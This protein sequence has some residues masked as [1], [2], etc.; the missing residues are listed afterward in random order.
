MAI[1]SSVMAKANVRFFLYTLLACALF[2]PA[3]AKVPAV[4]EVICKGKTSAPC[5]LYNDISDALNKGQIQQKAI[6]AFSSRYR[7]IVGNPTTPE[8]SDAL[9]RS[10]QMLANATAVLN[11]WAAHRDKDTT[12][13]KELLKIAACK[14]TA[15]CGAEFA[16][17]VVEYSQDHHDQLTLELSKLYSKDVK[18]RKEAEA[19]LPVVKREIEGWQ[20]DLLAQAGVL[21]GR[22][23]LAGEANAVIPI[24]EQKASAHPAGNLGEFLASLIGYRQE[25]ARR[26]QTQDEHFKKGTVLNAWEVNAPPTTTKHVEV[27]EYEYMGRS[28]FGAYVLSNDGS[29]RFTGLDANGASMTRRSFK[30]NGVVESWITYVESPGAAAQV[31]RYKNGRIVFDSKPEDAATPTPA[32]KVGVLFFRDGT[33]DKLI[34]EKINEKTYAINLGGSVQELH[35]SDGNGLLGF[36]V[37]LRE[38]AAKISVEQRRSCG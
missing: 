36:N 19:P 18:P 6:V 17:H 27:A 33:A 1:Q 21:R 30:T 25:L 34:G 11:Q 12:P 22:Y 10:A 4:E 13:L 23:G 32:V 15:D 37:D 16:T 20:E 38:L 28:F 26:M 9:R 8:G 35:E 31:R 14:T 29:E 24:L 7:D 2:A 3:H 5:G